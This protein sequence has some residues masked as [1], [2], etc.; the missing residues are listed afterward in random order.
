[1]KDSPEDMPYKLEIW[2]GDW[3]LPSVDVQCLKILAYARFSD[4]PL[5][6]VP[7]NNPFWTPN[8]ELPVLR[9]QKE[10]VPS[11][12]I[13]DFLRSRHQSSDFGLSPKEC[14]KVMTYETL[15]QEQLYPA[16]Q[17]VWWVDPVNF[18][19]LVRQW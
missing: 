14:A 7:T 4:T 6:V 19:G 1:M 11:R 10:A 13:L 8:G 15:L 3:G 9:T 17:F 16:M 18:N 5:E 12:R 2:K